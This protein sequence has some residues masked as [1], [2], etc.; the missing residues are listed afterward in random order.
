MDKERLKTLLYNAIIWI[1][2]D[3]ADYFTN[4]VGNEYK[5]FEDTIGITED[6]LNELE[7]ELSK[8]TDEDEEI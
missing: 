1:E 6:E 5:W 8:G 2:Q 7:I 3:C 4:E